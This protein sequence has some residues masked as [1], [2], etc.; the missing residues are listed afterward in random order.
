MRIKYVAAILLAVMLTAVT[1]AQSFAKEVV[2]Y[3]ARKD[4]LIK[5]LFDTYKK[6]QA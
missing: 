3:S 6:K 4:H 2:V 5:P 1:A